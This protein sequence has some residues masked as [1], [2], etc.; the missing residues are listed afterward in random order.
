MYNTQKGK[1][2]IKIEL[3]KDFLITVVKNTTNSKDFGGIQAVRQRMLQN[4]SMSNLYQ[5]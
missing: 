5:C 2:Q 4:I 3:S 1:I